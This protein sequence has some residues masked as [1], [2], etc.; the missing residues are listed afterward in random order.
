MGSQN[1]LVDYIEG[2]EWRAVNGAEYYMVSNFGRVK[3]LAGTGR[4]VVADRLLL[5]PV[6]TTGYPSVMLTYPDRVRFRKVHQLVSEAFIGTRKAGDFVNHIDGD[7]TNNR[8][9]NLEYTDRAGNTAHAVAAGLYRRG[10]E[11]GMAKLTDEQV[12]GIRAQFAAGADG[13]TV[14]EQYGISRSYAYNIN[15][16]RERANA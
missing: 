10:A 7:K 2:E 6:G 13:Q 9:D 3:R 1:I 11:H 8:V 4:G 5:T 15:A 14:A 12:R 16:G